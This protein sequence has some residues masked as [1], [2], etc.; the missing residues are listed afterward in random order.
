MV[1]ILL[2]F[3][4][5]Q[6]YVPT[7]NISV[8]GFGIFLIL[9]Y[10]GGHLVQA[11]GNALET[12]WWKLWGG[13]PTDWVWQGK[14]TLLSAAQMTALG[15]LTKKLGLGGSVDTKAM[16]SSAVSAMTRQVYALVASEGRAGRVDV[17]NGNYGLMRGIASALLFVACLIMATD[18][19]NWVVALAV[20]GGAAI[21][22]YRMHRFGRL[23]ARELF[24]QFLVLPLPEPDRPGRE[25]ADGSES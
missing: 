3:P 9:A 22:V 24:V 21:S 19:R 5:L 4:G 10:V 1:G 6:T 13:M 7:T 8:G 23:Y 20:L 18:F 16:P 14:R 15:E 12:I 25:D 17:F 2:L 11:I